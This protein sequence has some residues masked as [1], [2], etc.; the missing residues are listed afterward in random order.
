VHALV[1]QEEVA[2]AIQ[3]SNVAA[4]GGGGLLLALIDVGVEAH[5]TSSANKLMEPLRK[6]VGDFDFRRQFDRALATT[7]PTLGRLKAETPT[8]V[9]RPL[10]DAE[11]ATLLKGETNSVLSLATTYELSANF[12]S[13]VI[14]TVSLLWMRDREEPIYRGRYMY[15]TPPIGAF[16]KDEDATQAWAANKGAA[17]RAAMTEGIAETMKMLVIDLGPGVTPIA[18]PTPKLSISSTPALL[19]F[20]A[21]LQKEGNRY[22]VRQ[23][24]VLISVASDTAFTAAAPPAR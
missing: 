13:L 22:V 7:L 12:R 10:A 23:D 17:L 18:S 21:Y 20:P 14:T 8:T 11:R 5:R 9:A 6:A 2:A 15:Q 1:A 4:A 19:S 3:R 16:K 24:G